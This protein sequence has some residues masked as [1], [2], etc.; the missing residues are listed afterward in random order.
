[1]YFSI[2]NTYYSIHTYYVMNY[3]I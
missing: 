2:F 3:Y 1:M